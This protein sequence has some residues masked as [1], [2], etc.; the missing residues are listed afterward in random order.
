[1]LQG[2]AAG[3]HWVMIWPL[4]CGLAKAELYL[5]APEDLTGEIVQCT[6]LD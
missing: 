1:M 6:F 5:L 3:D 4:L 2:I